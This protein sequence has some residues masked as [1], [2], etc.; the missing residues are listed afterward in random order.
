MEIQLY[1]PNCNY[2]HKK[3]L[4]KKIDSYWVECNF[5]EASREVFPYLSTADIEQ[6][7]ENWRPTE[8]S[9]QENQLISD[10]LCYLVSK[11][12]K[13]VSSLPWYYPYSGHWNGYGPFQGI[14]KIEIKELKEISTIIVEV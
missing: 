8:E 12:L 10:C 2:H 11:D 3:W 9:L 5:E 1:W 14:K 13:S 6:S 4:Q 7:M